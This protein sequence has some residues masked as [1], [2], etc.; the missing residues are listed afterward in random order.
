MPHEKVSSLPL[1]RMPG[2]A[3]EGRKPQPNGPAAGAAPPSPPPREGP[4][5]RRNLP[6]SLKGYAPFKSHP[7]PLDDCLTRMR[8]QPGAWARDIVEWAARQ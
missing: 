3:A 8:V 6:P 7:E 1:K 4:L 5:G 2:P